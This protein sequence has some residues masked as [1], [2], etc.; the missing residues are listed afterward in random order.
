MAK[1]TNYL[2]HRASGSGT[3]A[4]TLAPAINFVLV[5]VKLHLDAAGGASEDFTIT[6]D[7]DTGT[8]YNVN[9]FTQAMLNT[10]DILWVPDRSVPFAD[11]DELDFAYANSNGQNYGL[12]AIYRQAI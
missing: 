1:W 3:I 8:K 6:V 5:G 9:L 12:E 10:I 2:Y 4:S 7:S 11:G